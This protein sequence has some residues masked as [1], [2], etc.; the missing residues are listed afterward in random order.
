MQDK[1]EKMLARLAM[2]SGL[3]PEYNK[4]FADCAEVITQLN[5]EL[6]SSRLENNNL[7]N[8]KELLKKAY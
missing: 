5:Q 4:I 3:D 2:Y 8:S 7:R 6:E 1:A